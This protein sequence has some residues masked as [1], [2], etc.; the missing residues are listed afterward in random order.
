[1][2]KDIVLTEN[3]ADQFLYRVGRSPLDFEEFTAIEDAAA[4]KLGRFKG[5]KL[6]GLTSLSDSAAASLSKS[7]ILMLNGL[8]SLSDSTAES[9]RNVE[10]RLHLSGLAALSDAAAKSLSNVGRLHLNGITSLS[11]SAAANLGEC[12][13]LSLDG[14]TTL[15]EDAA[16]SL[17]NVGELC[18]NGITSLS[19]SAAANL[20]EC[21]VL[22]LDGLT[23]LSEGAAESLS[24]VRRLY[25]NGIT[26][27]SDAAVKN[28]S[29]AGSLC[30]NSLTSLSDS[31]AASLCDVKEYLS[32]MGLTALSDEAAA[33]L[34]KHEGTLR[35]NR[36]S[37]LSDT[38]AESLSRHSGD[39]DIACF[40]L[41]PESTVR[42]L[43]DGAESHFRL[44]S[45]WKSIIDRELKASGW[46][47][48]D[49][50]AMDL[51][52]AKGIVVRDF[53]LKI[54]FVNYLLFINGRVI[55][56]IRLKHYMG[57][58]TDKKTHVMRNENIP[59]A[60]DVEKG[61]LPIL[62]VFFR[63]NRDDSGWILF[64]EKELSL[65]SVDG[66]NALS[67]EK[68]NRVLGAS[69]PVENRRYYTPRHDQNYFT[70]VWR[71]HVIHLTDG[72]DYQGPDLYA[73]DDL[74]D[75]NL[76]KVSLPGV[77]FH[78]VDLRGTNFTNADLSGAVLT[79]ANLQGVNFSGANLDGATLI[80]ANFQGVNFSGA[81]L[82]GAKFGSNQHEP[83][84]LRE[85][86]FTGASLKRTGFH[87][88]DFAGCVF[89][90]V[91]L[92]DAYFVRVNFSGVEFR[93]CCLINGMLVYTNLSGA[94]F[95]GCSMT[96]IAGGHLHYS[97][98][99][100]GHGIYFTEGYP[101]TGL[102]Y[103][104]SSRIKENKINN[105]KNSAEHIKNMLSG[106][107]MDANN[108]EVITCLCCKYFD[109]D[110]ST[111]SYAHACVEIMFEVARR[112]DQV[113]GRLSSTTKDNKKLRD[114]IK[115]YFDA[116]ELSDDKAKLFL[117][118]LASIERDFRRHFRDC[119]TN[120]TKELHNCIKWITTALNAIHL[121]FD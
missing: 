25:L 100:R 107:L 76:E 106:E 31:A 83:Q 96:E 35:F 14:L 50:D 93:G 3:I 42:I 112:C 13:V 71:K 15:S 51:S 28:L 57:S 64:S 10:E 49:F 53:Q 74:K 104:S 26:K 80:N 88:V 11:D 9:L 20:G 121:D 115:Q 65:R 87:N 81:N 97:F 68:I 86:K 63:R 72:G 108:N 44:R 19:D 6:N 41:L 58:K 27:L 21:D 105:V 119:K 85:T 43:K 118:G 62:N 67:F 73:H 95:R 16:R 47:A 8:T 30:L 82:D 48:Q 37:S 75:L 29:A 77:I 54:G 120:P 7:K 24:S 38:A 98:A 116:L 56:A 55:G 1:M 91:N 40:G 45:D 2:A 102:N 99:E 34:S 94:V 60:L 103:Y 84:D 92:T 33:T 117:R 23:T 12:D 46:Q 79:D 22:S 18:L 110:N 89:E 114:A 5:H 59:D 52:V 66:T 70:H 36:F 17:S 61:S 90:N 78:G 4:E 69:I 109:Y 101:P 32:L 113:V 111:V 39:L